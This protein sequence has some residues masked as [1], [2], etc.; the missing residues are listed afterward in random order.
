MGW[1]TRLDMAFN[2]DTSRMEVTRQL[3]PGNYP[4]KF[5]LDDVWSAS[6]DYPTMQVRA[7]AG[8]SGWEGGWV[9]AGGGGAQEGGRAGHSSSAL[10]LF[11]NVEPMSSQDSGGVQHICVCKAWG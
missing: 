2:P 5:V 11:L 1:H 8:G 4:F 7:R 9:V 10:C 6:F 3:L